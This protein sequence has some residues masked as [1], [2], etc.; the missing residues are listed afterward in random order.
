MDGV[1]AYSTRVSSVTDHKMRTH[2]PNR[3]ARGGKAVFQKRGE[4][5]AK[6]F[7]AS[8]GTFARKA[9]QSIQQWANWKASLEWQWQGPQ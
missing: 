6:K 8:L 3:G 1:D 2:I 4:K 7:H 5:S 9:Y